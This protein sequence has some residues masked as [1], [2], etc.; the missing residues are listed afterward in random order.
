MTRRAIIVGGGVGGLASAVALHREG[1]EVEVHERAPRISGPGNALT[2]WADAQEA[3]DELGIGDAVRARSPLHEHFELRRPDGR[4]VTSVDVGGEGEGPSP[5]VLTRSSL[6]RLLLDELPAGAVHTDSDIDP[7]VA[8]SA[9]CDVLVGAD[10]VHSR[11]R[12]ALFPASQPRYMGC[13]AWRGTADVDTAFHGQT[14]GPGRKFGVVPVE[15]EPAQWFACLTA[16]ADYRLGAH[17]QELRSLFAG[18]HDPIPRIIEATPE[19][20]IVRDEV[21][22]LAPAPETFAVD[23][24]VL[25]GDAAHAMTPD[26]GQGACQAL[27]DAVTLAACLRGADDPGQALADYDRARRRPTRRMA[28]ASRVLNRISRART[29][30][31]AR[32]S[33]IRIALRLPVARS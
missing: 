28:T 14:W 22:Q 17:H 13:I 30:P 18:W 4:V 3:L 29:M 33:A 9:E 16:P 27:I 25:V 23:N 15:D 32:L 5:R 1:W 6:M 2:L 31:R 11:I 19:S 7:H 12:T 8:L 26:L 10:G 20:E 24:A 21:C